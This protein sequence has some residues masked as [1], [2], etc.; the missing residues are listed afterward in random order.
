MNAVGVVT[1]QHHHF[2]AVQGIRRSQLYRDF[3]K[4]QLQPCDIGIKPNLLQVLLARGENIA[5]VHQLFDMERVPG[6]LLK[7]GIAANDVHRVAHI[8]VKPSAIGTRHGPG[9]PLFPLAELGSLY[10]RPHNRSRQHIARA[11][12]VLHAASR[13]RQ[14]ITLHCHCLDGGQCGLITAQTETTGF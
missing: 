13:D 9:W 1:L 4:Y 2:L 11:S 12:M 7:L 8:T 5:A 3:L 10:W 14:S 6:N